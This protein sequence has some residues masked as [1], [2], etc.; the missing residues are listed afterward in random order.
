M[1]EV[2]H[3]SLYSLSRSDNP[4]IGFIA[5]VIQEQ[6]TLRPDVPLDEI[7]APPTPPATQQPPNNH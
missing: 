3:I 1:I 4:S 7:M 2:S 6:T 5:L